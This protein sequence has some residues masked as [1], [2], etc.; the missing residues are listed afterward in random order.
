MESDKQAGPSE[1]EQLRSAISRSDDEVKRLKAREAALRRL[2]GHRDLELF[3]AGRD[4][5]Q[6]LH[7]HPVPDEGDDVES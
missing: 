6:V 3:R 2:V 7:I 4:P 1:L 5:D